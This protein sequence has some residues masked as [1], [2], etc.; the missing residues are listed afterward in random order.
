[1]HSFS[2]S[3]KFHVILANEILEDFIIA[4]DHSSAVQKIKIRD[5]GVNG[6]DDGFELSHGHDGYVV[7]HVFLALVY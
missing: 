4:S 2:V 1:M 6:Q 5:C 3:V 7:N